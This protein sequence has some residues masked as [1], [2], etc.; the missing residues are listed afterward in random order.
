MGVNPSLF[1]TAPSVTPSNS[2]TSIPSFSTSQLPP[3]FPPFQ[4]QQQSLDRSSPFNSNAPNLQQNYFQPI[5]PSLFP[6]SQQQA[7]FQFNPNAFPTFR[8]SPNTYEN[9][10]HSHEYNT[11]GHGHNH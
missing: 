8:A 9:H 4:Q 10:S 5:P 6:N 11:S 1:N 7:P 2:S 3:V